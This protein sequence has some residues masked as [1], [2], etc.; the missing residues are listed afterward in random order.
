MS[1]KKVRVALRKAREVATEEDWDEF[2][3][4]LTKKDG[5]S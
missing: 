2:V 1:S 4:K 5:K 3:K